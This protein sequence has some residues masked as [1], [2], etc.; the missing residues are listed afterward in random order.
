MLKLARSVGGCFHP[1]SR[2]PLIANNAVFQNTVRGF[3]RNRRVLPIILLE[4]CQLGLK[5][6][7][8]EVKP[9]YGRNFLIPQKK[10]AYATAENRALYLAGGKAGEGSVETVDSTDMDARRFISSYVH[11]L[12]KVSL[13]FVRS[14]GEN[15][16]H[17]PVT[18]RDILRKLEGHH[19]FIG[20]T[21][22]SLVF[23]EDK[24]V[25]QIGAYE[26]PVKLSSG[27]VTPGLGVFADF[28]RFEAPDVLIKVNI[29]AKYVLTEEQSQSKA[30][31]MKARKTERRS[32]KA[33]KARR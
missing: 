15:G 8:V 5:G 30:I 23:P 11:R 33:A 29:A 10:A 19:D 28:E 27:W 9:G 24:E 21:E 25:L 4:D 2:T 13:A 7:L 1:L 22:A 31:K 32:K 12:Q 26:L 14:N 17:E 18:K 6:E 3:K 20:F 16:L